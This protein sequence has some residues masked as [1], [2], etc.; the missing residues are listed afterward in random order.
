ML[1]GS[2]YTLIM[3]IV[4]LEVAAERT[5]NN[6][7]Y[8]EKKQLDCLNNVNVHTWSSTQHTCF[9]TVYADARSTV[10]HKNSTIKKTISIRALL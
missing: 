7:P 10:K 4:G 6:R 1:R 3:N 9:V 8:H 5:E 2:L